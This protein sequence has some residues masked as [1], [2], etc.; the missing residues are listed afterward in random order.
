MERLKYPVEEQEG[1]RNLSRSVSQPGK[2]PLHASQV[3]E[4]GRELADPAGVAAS[5]IRRMS[6]FWFFL[7]LCDFWHPGTGSCPGGGGQTSLKLIDGR[8][9]GEVRQAW[10]HVT[11]GLTLALSWS[12]GLGLISGPFWRQF[13]DSFWSSFRAPKVSRE[14]ARRHTES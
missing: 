3:T 5:A 4:A 8:S 1:I 14:V 11:F 9:P 12:T 13:R 7:E 10:G 2:L 6:P